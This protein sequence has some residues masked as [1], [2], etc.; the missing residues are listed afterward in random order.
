MDSDV[1]SE[2]DVHAVPIGRTFMKVVQLSPAWVADVS[3]GIVAHLRVSLDEIAQR[4]AFEVFS[5]EGDYPNFQYVDLLVDDA[6]PVALAEYEET[7]GYTY[8]RMPETLREPLG[9][10]KSLLE[11][12]ALDSTLLAW[13]PE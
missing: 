11:R 12:W 8:V 4:A 2:T 6:I 7:Q 3:L 5:E 1:P 13:P 9:L 10:V